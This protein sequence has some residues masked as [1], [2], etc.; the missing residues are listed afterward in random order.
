MRMKNLEMKVK[1]MIPMVNGL[2]SHVSYQFP[3]QIDISKEQLDLLFVT[4]YGMRNV[5]P[6]VLSIHDDGMTEL[7][8][9]ELTKLGDILSKYYKNKWDRLADVATKEYDPIY[10]YSD[11]FHEELI[12]TIEGND[13]LTHN[14]SVAQ[15]EEMSID[16][17]EEDSG[18]ERR[19]ETTQGSSTEG[20]TEIHEKAVS[21][22]VGG[23]ETVTK[24]ETTETN[25]TVTRTDNLSETTSKDVDSSD[26]RTDNLSESIVRDRDQTDTRTDN[27][28]E[29]IS[30]LTD[31]TTTRTDNL[32]EATQNANEAGIY[33]FNSALSSGANNS[34]GTGSKQN[35]GTQ[36][37]VLDGQE[38]QTKQNIGTQGNVIDEDEQV[39]K[40]NTGTQ[41]FDKDL[42]ETGS[43]LNSGTQETE[44]D[45]TVEVTGSESKTRSDTETGTDTTTIR[46]GLTDSTTGSKESTLYGGLVHTTDD[47]RTTEGTKRTTGTESTDNTSERQRSR[48]ATHLGNIG[49]L[50]TQ[51]LLR[52]EIELW[53]WNFIEQILSDAKDL[54]TIP[55]YM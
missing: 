2:F 19:T 36:T 17:T 37:T 40:Q 4:N 13:T 39:T 8:D 11:E 33:G 10:N 30:R 50:T 25:G 6:L 23:T 18:S 32:N 5:A 14:T 3:S 27:L 35:T 51:Q 48:D 41:T 44:T 21:K 26:T 16:R 20:G 43:K 12:E 38:S 24:S 29:T 55:V 45:D 7:S 15:S 1:T 9:G 53:R 42:S 47:S 22:T 28:S 31:D 34:N 49:N 52:E 54:I 46:G